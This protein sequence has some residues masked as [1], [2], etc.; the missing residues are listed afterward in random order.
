[1]LRLLAWPILCAMLF[2]L[3]SCSNFDKEFT[4]SSANTTIEVYTDG[5]AF[6][7]EHFDILVKKAENYG[8]VYVDI[9]QRFT[10]ASGGVHWRDFELAAARRDGIDEYY[11]KENNVPGYS[12][13]IGTEHCKSCSADLLTGVTKIQIAYWLGRL[14]RQEG[15]REVLF[16]PAYMGRV[17]GQGAKKTL[18]L[19]LPPGGTVRPSQQDRAAAYDITR[20]APNEILV[21]IPVGKADRELPDIEI[22]YPAGTFVTVTSGKRVQWWLSDHF[23]P[24]ISIL[25][26]LIVGLVAILKFRPYWLVPAPLITVDTKITQSISPALAAYLFRNWRADAAKAAFMASVCQ[27]AVKRTL[28]ISS[29]GDDAEASDLL[30]K[31]DRRRS[32]AGRA[33]WYDLP[34]ATRLVFNGIAKEPSAGDRRRVKNARPDVRDELHRTVTEEYQKI[35]GKD[36][37]SLAAAA[38]IL[39][40]GIAVA[41]FSG[42]LIFS[43]AICGILMVLLTVVTMFRHPE[44]FPVATGTS[45]QFKQA[46]GLFVGLPAIVIAALSYIGT[47]EVISEQR[48]YLMAILLHI[49]GIIAV[50]AMLRMPTPKQ[51]QVRNNMLD[52]SR[53][54]SGEIN[55]P[56]MSVECYEHYLPFAVALHVEQRWTERFNLWRESQKMNA[57]APDWLITS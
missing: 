2:V 52:L 47:T 33:K 38:S 35:R 49:A 27:L 46:A 21:S 48:P 18:T 13:Y 56:A 1:M 5:S 6:V 32:K 31:Q 41:Y 45:E 51:R 8:G 20:S 4:V 16:L 40:L 24:F 30:A 11:F 42:L 36:R 54:I 23:L 34:A 19:K 57:Y 50:L 28:R 53:Y 9:P 26:P 44:R 15:D 10:D 22:E 25:G 39:A 55:G 43:A 14:V 17:H 7:S 37:W 12:V 29:L 3:T